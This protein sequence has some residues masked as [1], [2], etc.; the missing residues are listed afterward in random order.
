MLQSVI[1]MDA[2]A[3]G[4]LYVLDG[5]LESV[6]PPKIVVYDLRINKQVKLSFIPFQLR[7]LKGWNSVLPPEKRSPA[8]LF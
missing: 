4:R 6:C 1:A 3:K 8:F 2:D 7:E 5:G